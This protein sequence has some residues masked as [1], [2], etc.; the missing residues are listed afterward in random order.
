MTIYDT[1][2]KKLAKQLEIDADTINKDTKIFDDLGADSL[3][4]VELIMEL[5]EEYN[6]IIT[7]D[8]AGDLSTVGAIVQFIESE[9]N[10]RA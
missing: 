1:V 6:I 9:I 3:D 10:K 4:L 5:E 7:N 2:R 8:M